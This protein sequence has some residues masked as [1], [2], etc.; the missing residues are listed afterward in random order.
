[1]A[2]MGSKP[3]DWSQCHLEAVIENLRDPVGVSVELVD[4][5]IGVAR[6]ALSIPTG[7]SHHRLTA[8]ELGIRSDRT[9]DHLRISADGDDPHE[10]CFLLSLIHI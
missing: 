1:M 10:L 9:G 3:I 5:K 6:N 7:I 4:E 8:E 2:S